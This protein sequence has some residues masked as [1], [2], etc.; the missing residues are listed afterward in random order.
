MGT[1]NN[2]TKAA[3]TRLAFFKADLK[4]E[5]QKT[6][7]KIFEVKQGNWA[8]I[9]SELTM[10]TGF[11]PELLQQLDFTHSLADWT[12]EDQS[13][14]SHF[15]K[16]PAINSLRDV[17]L[18]FNKSSLATT[19][20]DALPAKDKEATIQQLYTGLYQQE[21]T[22]VMIN[23]IKDPAVP[24]LNSAVGSTVASILA[25]QTDFNI[26]AN[27]VYELFKQEDLFKGIAADQ[28]ETVVKELK[29]L[30]RVVRISPEPAAVPALLSANFTTGYSVSEMPR[31]QFMTL[32]AGHQM[33][34]TLALQVHE[35]ASNYRAAGE[36]AMMGAMEMKKGS[37]IAMIDRAVMHGTDQTIEATDSTPKSPLNWD[38]LFGDADFCECGECT[39]VY[40]AAAY[41]VELLQYLRNNNLDKNADGSTKI[42]LNP[43]D[44]SGTPLQKLFDRRP[45]LGC[46]ELTCQ[47]TNTILP[48]VDL[49]NEVME[50][51]VV[52]NDPSKL[53]A[54][55]VEDET[56]SELLAQAQHTN[57]D[58][59][60]M[61]SKAVYPFILPYHQPIDAVRIFLEFLETS[62]YEVMDTFRSPRKKNAGPDT[63]P[64]ENELD[65]GS[66][67]ADSDVQLDQYH[68]TYLERATDAEF[69]KITQD[70]YVILTTE[71]FVSKEHWDKQCNKTHTIEEY[72]TAIHL[73][74]TCAYFGYG[75]DAEL[76]SMDDGAKEGLAF[77][78]KQFLPR[79]GVQYADLVQLLKT[80]YLNP[81]MPQGK[82]LAI[83]ETLRFSYRFLQ[84]LVVDG[85]STPK[86]KYE[87]LID[88]LT[89]TQDLVP[90]LDAYLHPDPCQATTINTCD[91]SKDLAQ[92]VYCYF[93]R[94]GK[95][96]VLENG[97]TCVNGFIP[98][99]EHY[100]NKS[101]E[102]KDCSIY[103]PESLATLEHTASNQEK[104]KKIGSV[105]C[106]TGKITLVDL[107]MD[108]LNKKKITLNNKI[109]GV[110]I[111]G[112][113]IRT[114]FTESCDIS[115]TQLIHLDGS[116]VTV[117][118]YDRFHRFIRLQ[119]KL[120]WT[121]DE[122][123]KA[124]I[125]LSKKMTN[126]E[127]GE[128]MPDNN[129]IDP[130]DNTDC[131]CGTAADADGASDC[132]DEAY[133]NLQFAEINTVL[134]HQL[135][136]VKKL[137]DKT[138][139]ELIKL[140]SFWTDISTAGE[141][142]LYARL[143]LTHN[144]LGIDKV[145]QAD[146]NGNYLTVDTDLK[147]HVPV[148]MAA[149][150]LSADDLNAVLKDAHLEGAKLTLPNISILYR[151][152]LLAKALGIRI[153]DF[154]TAYPLFTQP[155]GT[156]YHTL[157]FLETWEKMDNAGFNYKQLNYILKN[158]DDTNKPFAPSQKTILLLAKN[159]YDGQNAI[160][161]AHANLQPTSLNPT[162]EIAKAEIE[163]QATSDLVKEKTVL[164]YD[165]ASTDL[166]I[167]LLEG[168]NTYTTN[169]PTKLDAV[170]DGLDS[171]KDSPAIPVAANLLSLRTKLS[172]DWTK[173]DIKIKGILTD[174][175]ITAYAALSIDGGWKDALARIQKQQQ[176]LFKELLGTVFISVKDILL[177]GDIN[178]PA[179]QIADGAADPNTAPI[180][181]VTFLQVFLPYLR[182]QLRH[183]FIIDL[184]AG[185]AGLDQ[186]VT[187]L[188]VSSILQIN[189]KPIYA[190][191]ESIK[192]SSAPAQV[193]WEG[194]LIPAKGDDF[195]FIV[196][197][198]NAM[199]SL[200]IEGQAIAFVQ[201][202]DPTDEWWS[203]PVKL[204]AGKLYAL[205]V[206]GL[207][208]SL[209]DLTWKTATSTP[210][211]I[212]NS[213]LL[214][215]FAGDSTKT[216]FTALKK[217][218]ILINGFVLAA[219]EIDYLAGH[220][221]DFA[222]D[223]NA[224]DAAQWLRLEAYTRLRNSL[225]TATISILQFFQ[226]TST[227]SSPADKA[228]LGQKIA[229]L[230]LWKKER[231]DQLMAEAHFNCNNT[232][233]FRNGTKLLLLQ[234]AITVADKVGMDI[235][236]L[237]DWAKPSSNFNKC[238]IIAESIRKGI[239]AKYN[240]TD[241]EQ[242]VKPLN[243]QLREDQKNALISYLLVQDTVKDWGVTDANGL[244]E[245]FLI[246]VQMDAC[247]ETSRIKQAI[248][249]AQLFIQ[250]CFLGLEER[251]NAGG[252]ETGVGNQDLDRDRWNWM[253]RYRVWE[254]NRKVFLYPENWIDS[255]LRDDKSPFFKEL[256]SEL[257]Q[258]DINK[259]NVVDALRNY[260]Y[261][262]DEVASMEVVGLYIEMKK[263]EKGKETTTKLKLHVFARTRNAPYFFYYRYLDLTEMN[264]YAWEKMQVDI[265][266]YDVEDANGVVTANGCYLTPVLWNGRLLIFFPQIMKKT[267]PTTASTTGSFNSLGNNANGLQD[268]KPIEYYDIKMA[269]S[270]YRNGKWTQKQLSNKA[271]N[272]D[273]KVDIGTGTKVDRGIQDF[274]FIPK[275]KKE[276][277]AI[278]IEDNLRNDKDTYDGFTF[279]GSALLIENNNISTN[280]PTSIQT[281]F[282]GKTTFQKVADTIESLQLNADNAW[283]NDDAAF[284][285][286]DLTVSFNYTNAQISNVPFWNQL[287]H[288][289]LSN[290]NTQ[291]LEAFFN[292]NLGIGI[293]VDAGVTHVDQQL[294][295]NVFGAF[296]DDHDT[297]TANSYHELK[298]PYALYNWELFFHTPMMLADALS[299]AQQF[300]EAMKWYH[301]VFHPMADGEDD[302]RF[303]QYRP[304][305]EIDS[306]HILDKIFNTLQPNKANGPI[307]E[308]RNKPFMPHV[309]AR[310]R[311]V[312]YM[313]WVVMKYLDNI[314]AWGDYLFRQDTIESIN[315]AT[316]LY[317]MA[318][319]ILGQRPQFIP[320]RGKIKAQTYKSLLGKWDAF[321]NAVVELELMA[322]FSNQIN[323]PIVFTSQK[324]IGFA[325]V[326]GFASSLYFCI[327]NNPQLMAYWDTL[328]DRLF[329]IRH[330]ENI[331]GVF[332]KLPLFEPAI[333]PALLVKAAAQGLSI[334][335][336]LNDLNTPMPNYRFYYLLQKALE[337]CNELK[338]LGGAML[339]AIEKKDN[340]TISLI[341]AKHENTMQTL[342][343]E[344][345]KK[346]VEEAE[347]AMDGLLQNRK[348]PEHRMKYYLQ[349]IGEDAGK[350]PGLDTDFSEFANAIET[351]DGDSGL[352]LISFE[353]EDM[354]EAGN[355]QDMQDTIGKIESLASIFHAIPT[356]GVCATPIGVGGQ[357]QWGGP[358]L[359]HVTQ[360]I[361][362]WMQTDA[363]KHSYASTSAGKKAGFKRAL[364][365]RTMQANAAGYEIKQIDKQI[366]SQQIRIAIANQ[367]ITNQQKQIDNSQEVE[368][369]LK[370][371]YSNEEL[372]TW[373]RGNLKTLYHQVY[374]LAYDLAK[375]AEKTY[376]FERGLSSTAF[377]QGGYWDAGH[378]GL[379]AG[380]QLYV[381]LK[382]LEAA[383]QENRGY[384]YEITKHV[385]LRQIN[386]L[387]LLELKE[388]GK[389]EFALSE[390]LF[391][392]DYP[393]H[394]KRRIKSVSISIP[395]IAGPYTGINATLRLLESRFRNSSIPNNYPEKTEEA[396][397]RF[398][399]FIVPIG[400]IAASSGQNDSGMFELNFKD[401]RY[402][403]FEGAGT[404]SKW[405]LELPSFRQFDY[406][407]ISE[408][409]VHIRYTAA[410]GGDR[411]KK[412]ASANLAHFMK[413]TEDLAQRE[414]LFTIIDLKHD[415]PTEWHKATTVKDS[416]GDHTMELNKV[417]DF[418]PFYAMHA[419]A[420]LT[421]SDVYLISD[422]NNETF[423][424][425]E[426][427]FNE[428]IKIGGLK[429]FSLTGPS[430]AM[431]DWALTIQNMA[432][433]MDKA[434]LVVRFMVK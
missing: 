94:I 122:T 112:T 380:E 130:I 426:D 299:K 366:V 267:K 211:A 109:V 149:F 2:S 9:K 77:V 1:S 229:D 188:L 115:T 24:I 170:R 47:N 123:D 90:L 263:D 208:S 258:K 415:L 334:D 397:E 322:P 261:K 25:Q 296:D 389:C 269:W 49:V 181:R 88:F 256:E 62:R 151:Y 183:R 158:I 407:S 55:N 14:V 168:T 39:S 3:A 43:L 404:I 347:K 382:Q 319:H 255:N 326:F 387:A 329:K 106:K 114:D 285:I 33:D 243:D 245:Y 410:E 301:F 406:G 324:E 236:L 144:L 30:Q 153:P 22:A 72:D 248:S 23:M 197:K 328:E 40:S 343:M 167:G 289:L 244:F 367:E 126:A 434:F 371:K 146:K 385:S 204:Q 221:A 142:S 202:D 17:A 46:L 308:W 225:P 250:R 127:C 135:V 134:I 274:T 237:F 309:V 369:F 4:T 294:I 32:M 386:P 143:F 138:G 86:L 357:M 129:C 377:I 198:S 10:A 105:D 311:P 128:G 234:K 159:L 145:F 279:T 284:L 137:L 113:L 317:V 37:G 165:Q 316:Q 403:P 287:A 408:V 297:K 342:L 118:E 321:G 91:A 68:E 358:N 254:A 290:I 399:S 278:F 209:K 53:R 120:G 431:K 59:Y 375:K 169:A 411:L 148:L 374:S 231:I 338:S 133:G 428:S 332:R 348:S 207:N 56:S 264:W 93:E 79:T 13:L 177:K 394:Y 281:E 402:L 291:T 50:Q 361:A 433:V 419:P 97:C 312:A 121:I 373:M 372:Y 349:L 273:L 283:G 6:F 110:I 184:L 277:I 425:N 331:E 396:D 174:A 280:I 116:S 353:K 355:A 107:D 92:W 424:L 73:K 51:Y 65:A 260:L 64:T 414:G 365:E 75:T 214:P 38:L 300:E 85:A 194:F 147:D 393:G 233:Q 186:P 111:N 320:K 27:S 78:K 223:F 58:A 388:T 304:F 136:A 19:L 95:M 286:D 339:S 155:F 173:G 83:M 166:I 368:E 230:T 379:L 432:V 140:L 226:W 333:D 421:V 131:G 293:S 171:A 405:R 150:N 125:G 238:H 336:V 268:A 101:I 100:K 98:L 34:A 179:E 306:Q 418:M 412:A 246:D 67:N 218:A 422:A 163:N 391:D 259:Q 427:S 42:K 232:E 227:V 318:Y 337:L 60:C 276:S 272:A 392:M 70:E 57:Y 190:V 104:Q 262:A 189:G 239:R 161:L 61:L 124:I 103:L 400:A 117:E 271:L 295:D 215:N 210:T 132:K 416:N 35:N 241:W 420:S 363:S 216:A 228:L 18:Q 251:K 193:G 206:A 354:T 7:D 195:T 345:K 383:Y 249:S 69:L 313:K 370:N 187:D 222:I 247:M 74:P 409:V 235:D 176:K 275:T 160:D 178:I 310:S 162:P 54:F 175:E 63:D 390:I 200:T 199:P 417:Q 21:P 364:Q 26:R 270:E 302:K 224:L 219:D 185:Q 292:Y 356:I 423:L 344:I 45:D 8:A 378:D 12:N 36:H 44:I 66:A 108:F 341:R 28:Q 282:G 335:S 325:N 315:Q 323:T 164:L 376:R 346:Q 11:T 265:P 48:Y 429:L 29:T 305:K 360:A 71:A 362:R 102:F 303:W 96:I 350:V 119:Y 351:I 314:I 201:Q 172:Y 242:V 16:D 220:P 352:K 157:D 398:N 430:A 381:G 141:K 52:Y 31:S 154:I 288:Y 330:C 192:N 191:F 307:S 196:K 180:K 253:Q 5:Q 80:Q 84:S 298:R 359:G 212:A 152:R 41:F 99:G 81:N 89:Q 76:L 182:Q 413:S 340:E 257:L 203:K 266:S 213:L 395:C 401:E 327:P 384:D 87:I 252:T 15:Q 82:A 240:Q 139:L 205:K 217:A 20:K 156:A